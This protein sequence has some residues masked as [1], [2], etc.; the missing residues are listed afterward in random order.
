MATATTLAQAAGQAFD[1]LFVRWSTGVLKQR[2]DAFIGAASGSFPDADEGGRP[3]SNWFT[4]LIAT[5]EFLQSGQGPVTD[6]NTC[7]ETVYRMCWVA[8]YLRS[9]NLITVAQANSLLGAYN[10]QIG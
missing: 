9:Q 5:S 7:A 2:I 3:V 4:I 10:G 8:N 6:L 1:N